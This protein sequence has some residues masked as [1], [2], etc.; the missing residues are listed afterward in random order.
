MAEELIRVEGADALGRVAPLFHRWQE[1][2]VWTALQGRMG[3][4]WRLEN[5]GPALCR[6]GDF[7]FASE[8]GKAMLRAVDRWLDGCFGILALPQGDENVP[9][10]FGSRA[11]RTLRYAMQ[12]GGEH[13]EEKRLQEMSNALPQGLALC[14]MNRERY[15]EALSEEWSR[16][17]VALFA[18]TEDFLTHGLGVVCLHEG[19]MVGGASSYCCYD[20]GIEIEVDTRRDYRRRGIASACCAR[21]ILECLNRG[22]YPSWDAANRASAALAQKLGYREAGAYTAWYLNETTTE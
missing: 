21:L 4:V 8:G 6:T 9:G 18:S 13:F 5:A 22:L 16:D 12:K 7:L 3:Q 15:H 10:V 2:L 19:R 20:G 11:R 17:F 14:L 1:P